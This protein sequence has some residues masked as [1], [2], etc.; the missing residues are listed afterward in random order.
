AFGVFDPTALARFSTTRQTSV[1]TS[2]LDARTADAT[3]KSLTQP[4]SLS[5]TQTLPTGTQYIVQFAGSK[6]SR[7]NSF[8]NYNPLLTAGTSSTINQ[9]LLRDRGSYVNRIP[10]MQAQSNYKV[11]EYQLRSQ[12][13][14]LINAA[15]SAYWNLISARETLRVQ[16]KAR[17]TAAAYLQYMQQQ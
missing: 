2:A 6:T 16:E 10:I 11:S 13:L 1:P 3:T 12:L 17:D 4:Y 14:T 9:P 5:Y 15:E 7:T 8:A